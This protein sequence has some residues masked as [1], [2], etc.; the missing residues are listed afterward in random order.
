MAISIIEFTSLLH[1]IKV[2]RL[3]FPMTNIKQYQAHT[4]KKN[5]TLTTETN[6][7]QILQ[8]PFRP[9]II[10]LPVRLIS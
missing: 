5:L 3:C 1:S 6:V 9:D 7:F 10:I 2:N 8:S 4:L